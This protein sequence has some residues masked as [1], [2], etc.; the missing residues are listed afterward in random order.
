MSSWLTR[1]YL[2]FVST[3]DQ[4]NPGSGHNGNHSR[5]CEMQSPFLKKNRYDFS[6][7]ETMDCA[8]VTT[9]LPI[10]LMSSSQKWGR[11][12]WFSCNVIASLKYQFWLLTKYMVRAGAQQLLFP[13]SFSRLSMYISTTKDFSLNLSILR[14]V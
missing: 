6:L 4:G 2:L 10:L 7:I 5:V 12:A 13:I 1:S 11:V 14:I 3:D 9:Q 8:E